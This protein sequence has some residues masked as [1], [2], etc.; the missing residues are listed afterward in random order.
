MSAW[1]AY[2][3][4]R[5]ASKE[6]AAHA[7]AIKLQVDAT[8]ADNAVSRLGIQSRIGVF[9]LRLGLVIVSGGI[10]VG[11]TLWILTFPM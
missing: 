11:T 6:N 1:C 4:A 3:S 8:A 2:Q 5:F 10:V 9:E 7:D